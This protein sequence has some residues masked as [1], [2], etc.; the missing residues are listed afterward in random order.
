MRHI[1]KGRAIGN[2]AN[3]NLLLT[4]A[5]LAASAPVEAQIPQSEYAA[6]RA[7]VVTGL[8]SGI[9]LVIGSPAGTADY[10]PWFQ[11]SNFNYL[12]GFE[13][14]DA[15]LV[16]VVRDGAISGQPIIF[17]LPSD[18]AREVWEGHRIGVAGARQAFGF[19]A[20]PISTLNP[21]IDSLFAA[22]IP[23]NLHV[24]GDF[25]PNREVKTHD[26]QL[27][28][29]IAG[30]NQ[31]VAR[32]IHSRV[33]ASRRIKSAA[34]LDLLRKAIA[35]TVDAHREA[36]RALAPDMNEFEIQGLIEYTFRRN[37]AVR[38]GFGSIVGSGPNSTTLHYKTNDR[39]IRNGDIVVMD[40]EMPRQD[41]LA[42]TRRIREVAPHA[43]V[44]V[45]TAHRDPDWVVRAAQAGALESRQFAAHEVPFVKQPAFVRREVLEP[46]QHA[47]PHRGQVRL[48]VAQQLQHAQALP[49]ARTAREGDP[50]DVAR[51]ADTRGQHDVAM[52]PVPLEPAEP[53]VGNQCKVECHSAPLS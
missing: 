24:V 28:A 53:S 43:V 35:I 34:E 41:G 46:E 2:I 40:I 17:V 44:A 3:R 5:V 31:A 47:L 9:V 32:S 6:R 13:E 15:A 50:L 7:A 51:Q 25:R 27:V 45:V 37:G 29:A 42:A 12:T 4:I 48:C 19:D 14:P 20:R 39:V 33:N 16:M 36:A 38:P 1:E 22:G 18:P 23:R 52:L 11:A 49:L 10:I 30:R 8:P 26:D 21:V